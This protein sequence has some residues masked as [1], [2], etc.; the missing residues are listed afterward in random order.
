MTAYLE[1]EEEEEEFDDGEGAG[2]AAMT[3]DQHARLRSR[4][5]HFDEGA[6]VCVGRGRE[7]REEG[8]M[9]DVPTC[10]AAW[11]WC[12][13][14]RG[15][16]HCWSA[17]GHGVIRCMAAVSMRVHPA[18][19]CGQHSTPARGLLQREGEHRLAQAKTAPAPPPPVPG[20]RRRTIESESD[21]EEDM[22]VSIRIRV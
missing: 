6:E 14:C 17:V 22:A 10:P 18:L 12:V 11:P 7:R 20:K 1:E 3:N 15:H 5:S 13:G 16:V 8:G 19:R 21:E 9:C 4:S 2:I